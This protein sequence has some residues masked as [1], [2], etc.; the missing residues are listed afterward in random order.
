M[1]PVMRALSTLYSPPLVKRADDRP[2]S[3]GKRKRCWK[4]QQHCKVEGAGLDVGRFMLVVA[5]DRL[6]DRG[7]MAT[8]RRCR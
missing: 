7:R 4:G 5:R 6:A 1:L 2:G 3:D 8:P